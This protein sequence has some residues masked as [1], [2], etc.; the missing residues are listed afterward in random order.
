MIGSRLPN[1]IYTYVVGFLK[2]LVIRHATEDIWFVHP[3]AMLVY[4]LNVVQEFHYKQETHIV[5]KR[6]RGRMFV[7]CLSKRSTFVGCHG[8]LSSHYFHRKCGL[9][10]V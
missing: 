5:Q 7:Y 9:N 1:Y 3:S 2:C 6:T 8:I 10:W 4:A